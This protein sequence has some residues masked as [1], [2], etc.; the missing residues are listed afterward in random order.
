MMLMA[1]DP[2][3]GFQES[4]SVS[5]LVVPDACI[6][7]STAISHC[8]ASLFPPEITIA[9]GDES[10][11]LQ[12][13]VN[14]PDQVVLHAGDLLM[15]RPTPGI[16]SSDSGNFLAKSS[17]CDGSETSRPENGISQRV[18]SPHKAPAGPEGSAG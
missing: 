8:P 11:E 15:D 2:L 14:Q 9:A 10:A 5:L 7:H 4:V 3:P 18:A 12:R 6:F 16:V 13:M 1:G 17:R